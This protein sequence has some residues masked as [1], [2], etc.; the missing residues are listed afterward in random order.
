MKQNPW[1]FSSSWAPQYNLK[2]K[3]M[4]ISP[5]GD[6][7]QWQILQTSKSTADFSHILNILLHHNL[8]I[9]TMNLCCS[10]HSNI[11]GTTV[12][13]VLPEINYPE[14]AHLT[15]FCVCGHENMTEK[16]WS[17]KNALQRYVPPVPKYATGSILAS[18]TDLYFSTTGLPKVILILMLSALL[19][20]SL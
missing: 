14:N 15:F 7:R 6:Q 19:L 2:N 16:Y 10:F 13:G 20:L 11:C 12:W 4:N 1:K 18:S 17:I 8:K 5:L 3:L 9:Q